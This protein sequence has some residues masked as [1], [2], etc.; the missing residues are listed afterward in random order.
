MLKRKDFWV[1]ALLAYALAIFLP[2]A[3]LF[4]GMKGGS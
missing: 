1:G 3:K 2:P 4:G